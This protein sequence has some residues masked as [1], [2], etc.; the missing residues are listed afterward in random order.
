MN[1]TNLTNFIII[2][3]FFCFSLG[4]YAEENKSHYSG[5]M[6]IF[7]PGIMMADNEYQS[8]QSYSTS[9]GGILRMYFGDVGTAGLYGGHEKS[10]Y[11]TAGSEN[12][13][14]NLGYG[15]GFVGLSKK[16]K[17]FRYTA[18]AFAGMGSIQNLHIEKQLGSELTEAQLYKQAV[19]LYSPIL[20]VDYAIT[21][22]FYFTLQAICLMGEFQN[23]PF[24]NPTLQLGILFSR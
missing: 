3:L 21:K 1:L 5:G 11:T 2:F 6:L 7:Q 23:K 16:V 22:R 24:Y 10:Q 20:S 4:S 19:F 8:I 15:G 12:S 13:Y 14:F 18:S 9:I 17:R